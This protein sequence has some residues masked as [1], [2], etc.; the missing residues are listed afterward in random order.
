M[1][2]M[3]IFHFRED[4]ALLVLSEIARYGDFIDFKDDNT[5][6]VIEGIV[7][8]AMSMTLALVSIHEHDF[9][10]QE[11][12]ETTR[13]IIQMVL[14]PPKPPMSEEESYMFCKI[15]SISL[16]E[17]DDIERVLYHSRLKKS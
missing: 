4:K 15:N 14:I 6:K 5:L 17:S 7:I 8:D 9:C 10:T 1:R 3:E 11:S 16:Q 12:F 2:I 13:S